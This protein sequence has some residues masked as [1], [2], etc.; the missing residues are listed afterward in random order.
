MTNTRPL[1]CVLRWM[2]DHVKQ[3]QALASEE[4]QD[5]NDHTRAIGQARREAARNL[6]REVTEARHIFDELKRD[7]ERLDWVD[8]RRV[9]VMRANTR[10]EEWKVETMDG[11]FIRPH[12]RAAIDAALGRNWQRHEII[13]CPDAAPLQQKIDDL[14]DENFQ[15]LRAYRTLAESCTWYDEARGTWCWEHSSSFDGGYPTKDAAIESLLQ[16]LGVVAESEV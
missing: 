8:Q 13:Q 5:E 3:L 7:A 11:P 6:M 14:L 15:L 16:N 12:L 1:Y 9:V 4:E 10:P 2:E